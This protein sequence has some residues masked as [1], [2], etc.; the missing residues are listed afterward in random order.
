MVALV[1]EGRAEGS[2]VGATL[3]I[4]DGGGAAAE[5]ELAVCSASLRRATSFDP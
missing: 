5:A 2:T 1:D 4:T 3:G